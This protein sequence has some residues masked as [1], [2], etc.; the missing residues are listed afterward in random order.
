MENTINVL[1]SSAGRRGSLVTEFQEA[2]HRRGGK[3]FA[4]DINGLAPALFMADAAIRVP[5]VTDGEFI[6]RLLDIVEENRISLVVP[7]I[8]LELS[9]L[10]D[11]LALFEAKGTQ[12]AVSQPGLVEILGDK[13]ATTKFLLERGVVAPQTWLPEDLPSVLPQRVFVKPRF[14]SASKGAIAAEASLLESVLSVTSDPVIQEELIGPEI[15]IDALFDFGGTPIHFV[16]RRRL[17]TLGGES[18]QSVTLPFGDLADFL[19][20]LMEVLGAAGAR[21]PMTL[22]AFLTEKGPVVTDINPRFGGGAPLAFAAGGHY[23]EWLLRM[24]EG[25]VVKPCI[26]EYESGLFMTRVFEEIITRKSHW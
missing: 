18:I 3:V 12:V 11:A 16:P 26:G 20:P 10:A 21:G 14:G 1:I 2:A 5:P 4:T 19:V 9:M 13:L 25:E 7:T 8:D 15:T 17:L 23:P 24:T 22:Q 6:G